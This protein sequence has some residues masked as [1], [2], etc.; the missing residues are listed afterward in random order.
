M[1]PLD[2]D[3][4]FT[5]TSSQTNEDKERGYVLMQEPKNRKSGKKYSR[6]DFPSQYPMHLRVVRFMLPS[7]E[8][9]TLVTSLLRKTF[10]SG[11]IAELYHRC[12]GIETSCLV[13][14]KII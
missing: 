1:K 7:G 13:A 9:E 5:I 11:I 12:W 2:C 10:S 4:R 8:Y 6:W 14:V 3:I